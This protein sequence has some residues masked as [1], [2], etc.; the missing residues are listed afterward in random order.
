MW[1]RNDDQM[2]QP[3]YPFKPPAIMMLTPS[4]RFATGTRLCLSMSDFHPVR[5]CSVMAAF[6]KVGWHH[7][8]GLL[9]LTQESWNPMW[10][11]S[12]ILTGLLSFMV[13][14]QITTGSLKTT[15]SVLSLLYKHQ[16]LLFLLSQRRVLAFTCILQN[17]H[18]HRA[19]LLRRFPTTK[20]S[21]KRRFYT[22]LVDTHLHTCSRCA[23]FAG[24]GEAAVCSSIDRVQFTAYAAQV[25]VSERAANCHT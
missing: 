17:A 24:R 11:V 3:E 20:T 6:T 16:T 1:S 23:P 18:L 5:F 21:Y 12:S 14:D 15:V 22:R 19:L 9:R 8:S 7:L 2:L 4:G 25:H 13:E 10:T